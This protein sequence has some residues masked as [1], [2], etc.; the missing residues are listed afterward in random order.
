M[1]ETNPQRFMKQ[2]YQI[3]FKRFFSWSNYYENIDSI[4]ET[5]KNIEFSKRSESLT[6]NKGNTYVYNCFFHDMHTEGSGAA[7]SYE[8]QGS[9]ILIEKCL[10][11][12]NSARSQ[13]A[14]RVTAG[15]STLAFLCG[16]NCFSEVNDGFCSI[17]NDT[18][19]II[20]YVFDSSISKCKANNAYTM[21][22]QYGHVYIKSVNLSN[23]KAN[24]TSA[25][26][27][28]PYRPLT[29]GCNTYPW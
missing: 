12:H 19:R 17:H 26:C 27:C 13:A 9:N 8:K 22:H 29:A 18:T 4:E 28:T 7:I 21:A 3:Y 10:F 24:Y 6:P 14:I 1:K 23:N 2:N 25:L 11:Y 20:N 5:I 15:N 16:Q